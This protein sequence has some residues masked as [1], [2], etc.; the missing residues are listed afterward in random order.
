MSSDE[1]TYNN[2]NQKK[3]GRFGGNPG[4]FEIRVDL[5]IAQSVVVDWETVR[6]IMRVEK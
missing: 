4:E 6:T 5:V 2:N 3:S 1:P